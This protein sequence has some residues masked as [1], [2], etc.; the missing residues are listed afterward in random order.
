MIH[1]L[2]NMLGI[3]PN[4]YDFEYYMWLYE[5]ALNRHI[6]T[7]TGDERTWVTKNY[8]NLDIRWAARHGY[9]ETVKWLINQG[10]NPPADARYPAHVRQYLSKLYKS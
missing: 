9:L 4:Q 1:S 3:T 10:V 7:L 6:E 2:I 8:Y 5:C